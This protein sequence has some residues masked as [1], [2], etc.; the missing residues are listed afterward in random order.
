MI[1]VPPD[2]YDHE[3]GAGTCLSCANPRY[4]PFRA[5]THFGIPI[6]FHRCE[7][8]TIK[9]VPMPNERFFEWFFNS[10]LF[11]SSKETDSD[12]IWG[13]YD[14]FRDESCRMAQSERRF[15]WISKALGWSEKPQRI[16]KIG[17]S[18]G[19]FLYVAKQAGHDAWGCDVSDRFVGYAKDNYDIRIDL[20]RFEHQPYEPESADAVLL[21]N[22]I[23]NVPNLDEFVEAVRRILPVGGRFI[24]NHVEMAGNL[25]EGFQK[26]KYFI[27]R[28]PICYAF[29]RDG[30]NAFLGRHGFEPRMRR[31]D[32]R[33]LHLEKI[34]T[35]LRWKWLLKL[36]RLLGISRVTFPIWAYPSWITVYERTS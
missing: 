15:A 31:R 22:V 14:Y 11:F 27:Y 4:S 26:D 23:E 8:G 13:F 16:L 32:I 34:S 12:E 2:M 36:S 6:A 1:E 7:C 17:P 35:L 25:I 24:I 29:D 30:L 21:F 33:Y 9:Q 3:E 20:G 5:S 18:T 19:T 10:E 28:P